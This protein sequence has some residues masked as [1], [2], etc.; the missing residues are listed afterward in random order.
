MAFAIAGLF[1]DSET[2]ITGTECVNTSYPGFYEVL[3]KVLAHRLGAD[4]LVISQEPEE[5]VEV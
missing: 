1:A 5:A 2:V 3:Q 4:P